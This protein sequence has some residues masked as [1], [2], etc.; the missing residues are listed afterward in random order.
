MCGVWCRSEQERRSSYL[1]VGGWGMV[2]Q[3][4]RARPGHD[5]RYTW[6]PHPHPK[7][8]IEV[9]Q[10]SRWM[11][12][13]CE[14]DAISSGFAMCLGSVC[15]EWCEFNKYT[16]HLHFA[17][18]VLNVFAQAPRN[19]VLCRLVW[20]N[21]E[22]LWSLPKSASAQSCPAGRAARSDGALHHRQI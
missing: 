11:L 4:F 9:S 5:G 18:A 20:V 22:P 8:G 19:A 7:F 15:N 10:A 14:A 13:L 21:S 17:F 16:L 1:A 6:P 3:L 12:T 2:L